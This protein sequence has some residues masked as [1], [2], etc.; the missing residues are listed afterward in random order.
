M[1]KGKDPVTG[2][3]TKPPGT[4]EPSPLT[5]EELHE[6]E[7]KHI[8]W[9]KADVDKN[10]MVWSWRAPYREMR[11]AINRTR[12][13]KEVTD[14]PTDWVLIRFGVILARGLSASELMRYADQHDL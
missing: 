4:E 12:D 5:E 14:V 8:V 2:K 9:E 7:R 3:F 13:T 6:P 10:G 11:I 1:I